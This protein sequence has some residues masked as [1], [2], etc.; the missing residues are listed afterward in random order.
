MGMALNKRGLG[1]DGK[2]SRLRV[3]VFDQRK[4]STVLLRPRVH[5]APDRDEWK[6]FYRRNMGL[7]LN[8][9]T[10]IMKLK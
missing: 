8:T 4:N 1:F 7:Y 3:K 6:S 2:S 9:T 10:K 5:L